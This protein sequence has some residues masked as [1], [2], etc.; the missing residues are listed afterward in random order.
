MSD[1]SDR[2]IPATPR[3]REAARRQGSM[4]TAALPAWIATAGTAVVLLPSWAAATMSAAT[5]LLRGTIAVAGRPTWEPDGALVAGALRVALP[6]VA[7]VL[8]AAA[9]GIAVRVLLDGWS[10]QPARALPVWRRVD[11]LAG[12]ARIV[13]LRTLTATFGAAAGLGVV[14]LAAWTAITPL[15][16]ATTSLR[17]PSDVARSAWHAAITLLAA[18]AAVAITRWLFARRRFEAQ[19]RMTPEEFADESRDMQADPRIRLFQ[20]QPRRPAANTTGAAAS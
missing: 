4:P 20:R 9:A 18:G 13:S 8:V 17:E 16:A 15:V 12:L 19:I 2:V 11:P 3:R 1:A 6:T 5:D 7:V 10:W 14:G